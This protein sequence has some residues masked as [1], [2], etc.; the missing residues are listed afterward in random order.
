MQTKS[1]HWELLIPAA[2][3]GFWGKRGNLKNFSSF[4]W[5]FSAY[6]SPLPQQARE[7]Q[8][9]S[10]F[11]SIPPIFHDAP[12]LC[13]FA[14]CVLTSDRSF[15][16]IHS[17]PGKPLPFYADHF[18]SHTEINP[19]APRQPKPFIRLSGNH[20]F[21]LTGI[22]W[23]PIGILLPAQVWQESQTFYCLL[24]AL[25]T[26]QR[27][28]GGTAPFEVVLVGLQGRLAASSSSSADRG[29][30]HP[31]PPKQRLD[32]SSPS[33]FIT[34]NKHPLFNTPII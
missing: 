29:K 9:A 25:L 10:D 34:F 24:Y 11:S 1:E 31:P 21:M 26:S 5:N 27:S 2:Q 28:Q 17:T 23:K 33:K 3:C 4:Q 20:K 12:G 15:T 19:N 13:F 32:P 16:C 30:H 18:P 22:W 14:C 8:T 6:H 7:T